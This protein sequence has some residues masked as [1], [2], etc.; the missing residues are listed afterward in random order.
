MERRGEE[1]LLDFAARVGKVVDALPAGRISPL[2]DEVEQLCN[3][4]G[5]SIVTTKANQ[6]KAKGSPNS[7]RS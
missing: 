4:I 3:I 1:R 6:K 2:P 7:S 5:K